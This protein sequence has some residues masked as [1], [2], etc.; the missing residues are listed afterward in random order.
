MTDIVIGFMTALGLV[1][2][3]GTAGRR[4][5]TPNARVLLHQ[6]HGGMERQSAD[7]EIHAREIV[8]K[9]RE[10]AAERSRDAARRP[11]ASGRHVDHRPRSSAHVERVAREER[12][13]DRRDDLHHRLE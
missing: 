1:L 8:R 12:R 6:P 2:A 4:F 9:R 5:C 7:L 13:A 11:R 10:L 3:T